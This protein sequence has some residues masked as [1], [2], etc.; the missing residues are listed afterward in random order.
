M[1]NDTEHSTPVHSHYAGRFPAGTEQPV[2]LKKDGVKHIRRRPNNWQSKQVLS[3][4]L[5]CS[6]C[7]SGK[8]LA[9]VLQPGFDYERKVMEDLMSNRFASPL[10]IHTSGGVPEALSEFVEELEP[11]LP[12]ENPGDWCVSLQLEGASA[13]WA[14]IDMLLQQTSRFRKK[15]AVGEVSYHGP[16]STSLGSRTPLWDKPY[17]VQYP[18]PLAGEPLDE[19]L[20]I[21]KF[22]SFLN[23][24]E[25]EVGVILVEPQWGSSQAAYPWPSSLLKSYINLAKA[26][27]IYV[28]CDEIMCGLGRYGKGSL[29]VSK[30]L[31][32]DPDA[33]CFGK[34]IGGGVY[35][36]AGA[37][38]KKKLSGTVLQSHTYAGS[39][40]RALM[41]ATEV[42]REIP[43]WFQS[44]AKSGETMGNV[45]RHLQQISDG[46]LITHG[47]GLMW[48][49]LFS[50]QGMLSQ[51]NNRKMA[52]S[53][54]QKNCEE[55]GVLPYIVPAGG[56]MVTPVIDIG[57]ETIQ[58][59]GNKL[60]QV[61]LRTMRQIQWKGEL[62]QGEQKGEPLQGEQTKHKVLIRDNFQGHLPKTPAN[63][64]STVQTSA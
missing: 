2:V 38:L 42:L 15:V 9:K 13:V 40:V 43:R 16:P 24:H 11:H 59:I 60:E 61:V 48:G 57:V 14:A 7:F 27:G 44:I 30:T 19:A 39:S 23:Q 56:F 45:F 32:L 6:E 50:R 63:F 3:V 10:S 21:E 17:Q 28:V 33:I 5:A 26:R 8:R 49:A 4:G 35:P 34:A 58:E 1:T 62:L 52:T 64:A 53:C 55:L 31:D 47:Q 36:I 54:L 41:T 46:M 25:H 18:V 29:F 37:I 51:D 12:W 22:R 20:Y